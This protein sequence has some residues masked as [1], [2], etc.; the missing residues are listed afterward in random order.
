VSSALLRFP[1]DRFSWRFVGIVAAAMLAIIALGWNEQ[2]IAAGNRFVDIAAFYCGGWVLAHGGD[3]YLVHP[4]TE[5]ESSAHTFGHLTLTMTL[6]APLP[7]YVLIAFAL[8]ARVAPFAVVA[9]AWSALNLLAIAVSAEILRRRLP[10]PPL[11]VAALLVMATLS[12][13]VVYGQF[14]GVELLSIVGAGELLARGA[15]RR[16]AACCCIAMVEPHVG[17]APLLALT[18]LVPRAR[19]VVVA[20]AALVALA[21]GLAGPGLSLE[22][23]RDVL[24]AHAVA[25]VV[26]FTQY[27]LP[28]VLW[29]LHVPPSIALGIGGAV[30]VLALPGAVLAARYVV[31]RTGRIEGLPWTAAAIGT[32]AAPH[33]H[34]QQLACALPGLAFVLAS[35]PRRRAALVAVLG[36]AIPWLRLI[37]SPVGAVAAGFVSY[38]YLCGILPR[39]P[40]LY[41]S[42]GISVLASALMSLLVL[43]AKV[44]IPSGPP[45]AIVGNPLAEVPWAQT[46]GDRSG[47]LQIGTAFGRLP[48]WIALAACIG[49][50]FSARRTSRPIPTGV[51]S[52]PRSVA[53]TGA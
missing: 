37:V 34:F 22:Y 46:I 11:S 20:F 5:C 38:A 27:A 28:S 15:P 7:P 12:V 36:V 32:C 52:A 1:A 42:A 43:T 45:P 4:L 16:A 2:A 33:L 30:F 9:W 41:V 35:D 48:T 23:V 51:A 3:P 13:G 10:L 17:L 24:P 8:A 6:P 53:Q 31:A 39:R 47:V 26:D 44:T 29:L 19:P 14:T 40:A 25:N 49:F 50:A 21:S 18:I